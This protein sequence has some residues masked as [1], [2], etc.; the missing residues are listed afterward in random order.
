M[1]RKTRLKTWIVMVIVVITCFCGL[2]FADDLAPINDSAKF[3]T[4]A[5]ILHF[6]VCVLSWIWIIFAKLAWELLTNKWVYWEVLWLD[7]IL[8]Q[9]R[10]VVKN[11]ANYCLGF[12]FVYTVFSAMFKKD[13]ISKKIKDVLLWMVVAWIWIQA[14]RFF[15]AVVV[16]V[17]TVTIAAAW[18]FPSQVISNYAGFDEEIRKSM[19]DKFQWPTVTTWIQYVLFPNNSRANNF[20]EQMPIKIATW[21]TAEQV[22]DA[23]MPSADDVWWPLYYMWVSII[24]TFTINSINAA[25]DKDLKTTILDVIIQWGTTI[26]YSIEMWVLCIL[27]LMRIL[28]LW[29]FIVLSPIVVLLRCIQKSWT[30]LGWEW[31]FAFVDGFTKEVNFKSFF[32]NVFKPTII[33]IWIWLTVMLVSLIKWTINST[34]VFSSVPLW[35][36]T[37]VSQETN[38]NTTN[39]DRKYSTSI[40]SDSGLLTYTLEHVWKGLLDFILSIITVVLVYFVIS[41]AM[42]MGWWT[43]FVSKRIKKLQD[44]IWS[45]MTSIPIVPVSWYDEKWVPTTK[46][47]STNSALWIWWKP[48]LLEGKINARDRKFRDVSAS[49][50]TKILNA[51]WLVDDKGLDPLR[52]NKVRQANGKTGWQKLVE[53][54][55]IIDGIKTPKWRWMKLDPNAPDKFWIWEFE[56]WLTEMNGHEGEIYGVSSSDR[57]V[58]VKMIQTWNG[59]NEDGRTL[60]KLFREVPWSYQAYANFF[61]LWTIT[62]W[63]LLIEKDISSED[64]TE[65]E[66]EPTQPQS[67]DGWWTTWDVWWWTGWT[68]GSW[69]GTSS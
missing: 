10:N 19:S 41:M 47:I 25:S 9:Y 1:N 69:W 27:A 61:N 31:L 46:Y 56:G 28:Y 14:S 15:T 16:D 62:S 45:T 33:V 65:W 42:T 35:W 43:D 30:K 32:I 7:S 4:I 13:D 49:D 67:S 36:V 50:E 8:W 53:Q 5:R 55:S 20:V 52:Q 11:L 26:I 39:S 37:I 17:S 48:S 40:I 12:Y 44:W 6:L 58:W 51:W 57:E 54:R 68:G 24:D 3:G 34:S 2:S 66:T 64:D 59:T 63:A 22:V 23:I 18:A 38:G 21:M 29:M 60:E